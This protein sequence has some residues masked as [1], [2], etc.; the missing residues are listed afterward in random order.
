MQYIIPALLRIFDWKKSPWNK[1]T[2]TGQRGVF[3]LRAL[4]SAKPDAVGSISSSS[5]KNAQPCAT[6]ITHKEEP[7]LQIIHSEKK[8]RVLP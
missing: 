1:T 3:P 4:V 8:T 7:H 5:R 2:G 6:D